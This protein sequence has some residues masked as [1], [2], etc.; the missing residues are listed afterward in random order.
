MT[1]PLRD[2]IRACL[3]AFDPDGT[4]AAHTAWVFP[5][6][7]TGFRGHFPENPVCPGVCLVIAQL[8]AASRLAGSRLELLEL[9]NIKFMWPVFPDKRVDGR[10]RITSVGDARWRIQAELMR[11]ERRIAKFLLLARETGEGAQ[12]SHE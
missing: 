3:T 5:R 10:L 2:E 4:H 6:G 8:E 9:D 11:G 12:P 7:F 1:Q